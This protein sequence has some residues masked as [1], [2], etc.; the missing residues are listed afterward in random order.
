MQQ[1][2]ELPVG[3]CIDAALDVLGVVIPADEAPGA[4]EN[5]AR[6]PRRRGLP[7]LGDIQ[8]PMNIS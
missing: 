3:L 1:G 5:V 7:R 2:C 6:P 4:V 8:G